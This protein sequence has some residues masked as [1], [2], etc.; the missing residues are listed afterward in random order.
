MDSFLICILV[1]SCENQNQN[2][3]VVAKKC[4]KKCA[5]CE[6]LLVSLSLPLP[7]SPCVLTCSNREKPFRHV[8]MEAKFLDLNK[9]WLCKY[10]RK[11]RRKKITSTTFL[12][13]TALRNKTVAHNFLPLFDNANGRL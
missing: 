8:A 12:C 11:K 2:R 7:Y 4:T 1:T 3:N 9:P 6:K 5:A 10:W 13:M